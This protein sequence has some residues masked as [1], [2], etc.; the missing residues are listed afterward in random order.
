MDIYLPGLPQLAR[1]MHSSPSTAQLTI[2]TYL[3]GIVVGQIVLGPVSDARGRRRPLIAGLAVFTLVALCCTVAPDIY[4]LAALRVIQGATAAIAMS[5]G[6]AI[7]R[8]LYAGAAAARYL[9][10]LV[11]II[12]LGP[13]I[14]PVVGA[15]ILRIASWRGVFVA[16]V[17]FGSLLTFVVARLLPE[18]LPPEKRRVA[19]FREALR[20]YATLLGDREFVALVLIVGFGGGAFLTYIAGSSFALEDVY[21]ASPQLFG[22]LFAMNGAFLVC[23]AQVNAR[24]LYTRP[25]EQMLSAGGV[26]MGLGALGFVGV[27]CAPAIGP[28]IANIPLTFVAM[29][30]SLIQS[31]ALALAMNNYPRAAGAAASL[32]GMSQFAF[33]AVCAPIVGI[34]SQAN[35]ASMAAVLIICAAGAGG[36][37]V[38]R[39]RTKR[40]PAALPNAS[41]RSDFA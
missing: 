11:L 26:V 16:L 23:V 4:V 15:Q 41:P 10:R 17:L 13:I 3:I 8:D 14:A 30:W 35:A 27:V 12:G 2:T 1:S 21:H 33:G 40:S 38:F 19:G 22:F 9:S 32:L 37:L 20:S 18:T 36:A 24:L 6:R 31:N 7:V 28:L 5:I 25:V 29:S 39:A 34:H